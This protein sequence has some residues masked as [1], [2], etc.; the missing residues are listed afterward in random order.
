M[1]INFNI[2]TF[3]HKSEQ[4]FQCG[5]FTFPSNPRQR[6]IKYSTTTIPVNCFIILGKG[7][8]KNEYA[9]LPI[10]LAPPHPAKARPHA[11]ISRPLNNLPLDRIIRRGAP[12]P[13]NRPFGRV[14]QYQFQ[15][16]T[17]RHRAG[18][19]LPPPRFRQR[20]VSAC[21]DIQSIA[22]ILALH[23][24]VPSARHR[25]ACE[26][27]ALSTSIWRSA[28]RGEPAVIP[29][30]ITPLPSAESVQRGGESE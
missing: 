21:H 5:N 13:P 18:R 22:I 2:L 25:V 12:R 9:S 6:I 1:S 29:Q 3:I 11:D 8:H 17:V 14:T 20:A 4:I 16:G 28:A 26:Q 24:K 15:V 19:I 23:Q 10:M 30:T 27:G 7:V